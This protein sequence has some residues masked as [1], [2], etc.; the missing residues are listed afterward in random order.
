[1]PHRSDRDIARDAANVDSGFCNPR[2]IRAAAEAHED[3]ID[4]L[5]SRGYSRSEAEQMICDEE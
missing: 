1:M 2:K 4:Q 5:E 3:A